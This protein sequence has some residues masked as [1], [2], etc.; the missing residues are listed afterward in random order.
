MRF[1]VR[2]VGFTAA[3]I[4]DASGV[5]EFPFAGDVHPIMFI[6]FVVCFG[7]KSGVFHG[8][9]WGFS[10]GLAIWF[11]TAGPQAL[12]FPLAGL[13]AGAVP[14]LLRPLV[15]WRRWTGQISLGFV[16]VIIYNAVLIAVAALRGDL[17]GF[18]W[19]MAGRVAVDAALTAI[20][21][22]FLYAALAAV[23]RE[24]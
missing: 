17:A 10:G 16:V 11:L 8:G 3:L 24:D 18:S 6:A 9:V 7:L 22:P 20:V 12:A 19:A 14:L 13:V 2:F 5:L 21:C 4:I 15:F 23:E 1:L